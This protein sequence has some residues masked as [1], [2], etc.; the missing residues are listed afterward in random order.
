MMMI[1]MMKIVYAQ[2]PHRGSKLTL[3]CPGATWSDQ[4][5]PDQD[6]NSH[7]SNNCGG[8]L[9]QTFQHICYYPNLKKDKSLSSRSQIFHLR[10]SF[11]TEINEF[12]SAIILFQ[13]VGRTMPRYCLFG[14][15][16]NVASRMQVVLP[17]E[18]WPLCL[19]CVVSRVSFRCSDNRRGDEDPDHLRNPRLA[20]H[21][22]WLLLCPQVTR[23]LSQLIF[24]HLLSNSLVG[25]IYSPASFLSCSEPP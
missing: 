8:I 12:L 15:T 17:Q 2:V 13:V 11:P 21:S 16:V 20:G 4:A 3:I 24:L 22:W 9:K 1:M 7:R 10:W 23:P 18:E 5:P 14:D 19:L 6:G 25:L